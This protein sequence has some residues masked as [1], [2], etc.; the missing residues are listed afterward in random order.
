MKLL[1]L[2][3]GQGSAQAS[4][5]LPLNQVLNVST[6]GRFTADS[7]RGLQKDDGKQSVYVCLQMSQGTQI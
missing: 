6:W 1:D 3:E 2:P 4:Q 7:D 5:S